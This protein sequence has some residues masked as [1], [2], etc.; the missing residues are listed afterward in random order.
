M[1]ERSSKPKRPRDV[2]QRA[3]LIVDIATGE[4]ED[5]NPD[6]GKNPHAVALGRLGGQKGGKARA[7]SVEEYTNGM[8]DLAEV[9]HDQA[10]GPGF[11]SAGSIYFVRKEIGDWGLGKSKGRGPLNLSALVTRR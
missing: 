5:E 6:E 7:S 10:Y 1:P 9:I 11:F 4:V 3:K 2:S 8:A